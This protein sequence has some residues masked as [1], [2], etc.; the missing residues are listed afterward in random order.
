MK[1]IT[2][3]ITDS[4]SGNT[5]LRY[6]L[7]TDDPKAPKGWYELHDSIEIALQ[8]CYKIKAKTIIIKLE[9]DE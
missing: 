9:E 4:G 8:E 5:Q 6:G 3:T 1:N 2:A 7:T